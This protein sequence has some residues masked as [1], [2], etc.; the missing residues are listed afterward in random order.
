MAGL[1]LLLV[2][3]PEFVY[4]RDNFGTR[5]NTIFKFYYQSWLLFGL[6][7]SYAIVQA[8]RPRQTSNRGSR[9]TARISAIVALVLVAAGL[10]YPV[11]GVYS[12]TVG[13]RS[14]SP[15]FDATAYL[16]GEDP[17]E[18]AAA[19]W[20]R[21]QT[22]PDA[23]VLEG[24]GASYRANYQSHQHHDWTA[25]PCWAGTAMSLSGAAAHTARWRPGEL[26]PSN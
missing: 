5:M 18:L 11:A 10:I 8:L 20:V 13:F 6:S 4:L 12:K 1:G 7:G 17:A 9:I 2:Y 19:R 3:A 14:E 21:T 24:K 22:A 23:L 16:Q 25:Q 26:R 15:T